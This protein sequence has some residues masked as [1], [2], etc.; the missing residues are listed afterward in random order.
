MVLAPNMG[1]KQVIERRHRPPPGNILA[2]L[3]PL[4]VLIEHRIDNMDEGLVAVEKTVA[5][6]KKIAFEPALTEVL[7]QNLHYAAV[8]TEM[9]IEW[10]AFGNP[11]PICRLEDGIEPV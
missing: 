5:A 6:C 10:L 4:G 1:A 9:D 7:A 3:Q 8:R 11:V 2:D